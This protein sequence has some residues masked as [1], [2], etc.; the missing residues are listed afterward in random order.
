[1]ASALGKVWQSV[2]AMPRPAGLAGVPGYVGASP[3]PN[4]SARST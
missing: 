3:T 1:M 4:A 2:L